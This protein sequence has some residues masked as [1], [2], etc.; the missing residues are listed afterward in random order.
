MKIK[1]MILALFITLMLGMGAKEVYASESSAINNLDT[2]VV[3]IRIDEFTLDDEGKEVP[4][5]DGIGVLPGMSVSKIPYFTATG[6]DCYIRATVKIEGGVK[7]EYPITLDSLQGIS[8]DW[9]RV[10]DYF[11]Y[12]YP[13]GTNESI[14]FFHSFLIP[15]EWGDELNPS[16]AGDWGF[17][18]IVVVDAIQSDNFSPDFESDSPWGNVTIQESIH[19]DGYDMNV[20]TENKETNMSVII[21]DVDNIIVKPKDFFEGFKTMVP[22]DVLTD[23]VTIH[24]KE[25]GEVFFTAE[26][27]TDIDLL[28]KMYL[29]IVLIKEGKETLLYDDVLDADIKNLSLGMFHEG[30]K[31]KLIFTV[32]M[33]EE[34]DNE[35]TL[36]NAS[37]KWSFHIKPSQIGNPITG[38]DKPMVMLATVMAASGGIVILLLKRRKKEEKA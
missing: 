29:K 23:S 27:L 34:L 20:F 22:G 24:S 6:N 31:A 21:E 10:G 25:N 38:D 8:N 7:T 9:I 33:P 1:I 12:K 2:G 17:S 37:V 15:G 32:Y 4:W 16:N 28:Q 19:K 13:L 3:N 11:Y 26:S 35:Y 5:V 18:L 14:D 30:E 36:R